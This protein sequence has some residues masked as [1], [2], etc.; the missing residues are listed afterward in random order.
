M[1]SICTSWT[2]S[3]G[4]FDRKGSAEGGG[5]D[6]SAHSELPFQDQRTGRGAGPGGPS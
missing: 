4:A 6:G 3:L 2:I 1:S 5:Q